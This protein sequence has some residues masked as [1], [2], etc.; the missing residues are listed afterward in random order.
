MTTETL[1]LDLLHKSTPRSLIAT[2]LNITPKM[3]DKAVKRLIATNKRPPP[4]APEPSKQAPTKPKPTFA[5]LYG[6]GLS[7]EQMATAL[8]ASV[9][10]IEDLVESLKNQRLA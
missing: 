7:Y 4:Y 2:T 1:V 6:T 9:L 8:H 5:M 10:E 3:V